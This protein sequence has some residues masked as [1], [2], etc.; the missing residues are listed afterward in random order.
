VTSPT[1]DIID[2]LATW[3]CTDCMVARENDEWPEMQDDDT[4]WP[5]SLFTEAEWGE[6][7]TPG[8]VVTNWITRDDVT[9]EI[10]EGFDEFSPARCSG[11]GQT[12]AGSRW[13]Y[14]EWPATS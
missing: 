7:V 14:A 4:P 9:N 3:V 10:A 8:P 13:R 12:L 1:D 6:R 5:W 11:C 2:S